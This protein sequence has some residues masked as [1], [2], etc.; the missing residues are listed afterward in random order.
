MNT[1]EIIAAMQAGVESA[2][3]G[4][5][6]VMTNV[7]EQI[8]MVASGVPRASIM[9]TDM[10]REGG[11]LKGGQVTRLT[12][13]MIV[14]VSVEYST[15]MVES[16]D[17]TDSV[18]D[19]FPEGVYASITGGNIVITKP[20]ETRSGFREGDEWVVPVAVSFLA[21]TTT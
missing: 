5:P 18:I 17:Y 7:D 8:A 6:V 21:T 10:P 11:T 19:Q 12:S 2:L 13:R 9:F 14:M 16:N 20:A 3:S 1:N 15:G 4:V